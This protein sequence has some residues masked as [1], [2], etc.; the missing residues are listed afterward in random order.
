MSSALTQL[1]SFNGKYSLPYLIHLYGSYTKNGE[2]QT[3]DMRFINDV[4][5]CQYDGQTYKAEAF[6][7][8]PNASEYGMTG[9]G[10]LEI[11]V[12]GNQIIDLVEQCRSITLEVVGCMME[13]GTITEL[14][15]FKH[16]NGTIKV[17]RNTA[18]FT[19]KRDER[20]DM[21]FPALVWNTQNNRG[22]G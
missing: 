8:T 12:V 1:F 5:S 18:T 10:T 16:K 22:N 21:T 7:Y 17:N 19:F 13:D 2:T 14:R 3:I 4:K 20:L 15:Q 6:N 11:S 9:G